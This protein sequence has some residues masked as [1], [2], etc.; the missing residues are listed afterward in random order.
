MRP[1]DGQ[2]EVEREKADAGLSSDD[3]NPAEVHYRFRKTRVHK[4]I[5]R[6]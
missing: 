5:E 2:P 3:A 6:R 4:T 1:L